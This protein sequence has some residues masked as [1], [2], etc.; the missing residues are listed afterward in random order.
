MG[1]GLQYCAV[2][3]ASL[4][5]AGEFERVD[6][7]GKLVKEGRIRREIHSQSGLISAALLREFPSFASYSFWYTKPFEHPNN[8]GSI[9]LGR[10]TLAD[11][12]GMQE[13]KLTFLDSINYSIYGS[14]SG[15]ISASQSKAVD[16]SGSGIAILASDWSNTAVAGDLIY[17]CG[18]TV[19]PLVAAIC[20]K[21][22][23][24]ELINEMMSKQAVEGDLKLLQSSIKRWNQRLMDIRDGGLDV[25]ARKYVDVG[26]RMS[27]PV[28]AMSEL[29]ED[30][31]AYRG[32]ND[33]GPTA[34]TEP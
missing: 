5:A 32:V 10:A 27:L 18:Y 4:A 34:G 21:L 12:V 20:A 17:I 23:A 6:D 8:T 28:W 22:T 1:I 15:L 30:Q 9:S 13:I 11:S 3:D 2:I 29:G 26:S 31:S 14:E 33:P 24:Y 16:F 25:G 19:H 7:L